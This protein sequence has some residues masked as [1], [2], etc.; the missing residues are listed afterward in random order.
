[1]CLRA[2]CITMYKKA[3]PAAFLNYF[4]REFRVARARIGANKIHE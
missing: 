1:M 4:G 2:G 3:L